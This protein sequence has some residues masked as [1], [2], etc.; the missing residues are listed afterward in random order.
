MR[1]DV[2]ADVLDRRR[3]A[4]AADG[5]LVLG[6][7]V[8]LGDGDDVGVVGLGGGEVGAAVGV[9]GHVGEEVG[10]VVVVGVRV[11]AA[12]GALDE[13][14]HQLVHGDLAGGEVLGHGALEGEEALE[15]VGFDH[16]GEEHGDFVGV[17]LFRVL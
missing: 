13:A 7:D 5:G 17:G 6:E 9:L 16:V 15:G 3:N 4:T 1:T 8:E 12:L 10:Q 14:V 2:E 11:V